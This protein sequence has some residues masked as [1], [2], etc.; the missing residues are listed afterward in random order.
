MTYLQFHL[1]F[2]LPPIAALLFLVLRR[3][4][5]ARTGGAKPWAMLGLILFA[6]FVYTTPWDN[7][8]VYRE[9]WTY[10]P[11][12]VL[13][14]IGYVPVEEY[15]FFLLQPILTGLFLFLLLQT[16]P[17]SPEPVLSPAAPRRVGA[18]VWMLVTLSGVAMLIAGGQW[19]YMGLILAW[20]PFVLAGLWWMGGHTA[21]A[22]RR[23]YALAVAIPTLYLWYADRTAI[24]L[25]IWD[26]TD[27]TRTGAEPLGLPIEEAIFFLLTNL[28]VVHG[29]IM[30][31]LTD[32]ADAARAAQP[33]RAQ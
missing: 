12:A 11:G 26:I 13:A 4:P 32:E 14:T 33:A 3:R 5:V 10:P 18:T 20:A 15:A 29:L 22:W 25:G 24:A 2:I 17:L 30:L 6:A 27:A 23:L 28:L 19:L 9:V 7:Y 16:T 1:T 8:L 31:L 21:W